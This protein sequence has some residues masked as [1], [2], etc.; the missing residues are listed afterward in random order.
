LRFERDEILHQL[1]EDVERNGATSG[2]VHSSAADAR[3]AFAT[4]ARSEDWPPRGRPIDYQKKRARMFP[5]YVNRQLAW[6]VL[7]VLWAR[8]QARR[9]AK[10]RGLSG[11]RE[12]IEKIALRYIAQKIPD[13]LRIADGTAGRPGKLGPVVL[14]PAEAARHILRNFSALADRLKTPR[15]ARRHFGAEHLSRRRRQKT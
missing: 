12:V 8:Q 11:R 9:E 4:I 13:G 5:D 10:R 3:R 2:N 15:A 7:V 6:S 14:A 1:F